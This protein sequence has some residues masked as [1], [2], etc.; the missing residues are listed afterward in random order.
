M[1]SF[2]KPLVE[3]IQAKVHEL[4]EQT[5][6]KEGYSAK[7]IFMVGGFSESP[8]LKSEIKKKISKS[9]NN[10]FN[11]KKTFNISNKRSM[12]VWIKSKNNNK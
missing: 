9:R 8:Y 7:F 3:K 11:T 10:S 6:K 4:L 1:L 5:K 12:H 2:F